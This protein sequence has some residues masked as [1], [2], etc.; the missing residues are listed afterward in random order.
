MNSMYYKFI[1]IHLAF[2]WNVYEIIYILFQDQNNK[3]GLGKVSKLFICREPGCN[4]VYTKP[5]LLKVHLYTHSGTKIYKV[6]IH[7]NLV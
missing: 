2:N 5:Y 7:R 1:L 4:K 3:L 6:S